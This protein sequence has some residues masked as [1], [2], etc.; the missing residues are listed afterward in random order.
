M[1]IG[2]IAPVFGVILIGEL[3]DKTF[4][5]NLIM[6]SRHRSAPVWV[7]SAIAF[8]VHVVIAV[9]AGNLIAMLPH[10]PVQIVVAAF[11]GAGAAVLL[12]TKEKDQISEGEHE[13][14]LMEVGNRASDARKIAL[15]SFGIIFLGEWGDLT[16]ILI[17]NFSAKYHDPL[18]VGI[19]SLAGLLVALSIAVASGRVLL[20]V[21][22]M[23]MIRRASGL[24]LAGFAIWTIVDAIKS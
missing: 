6:A 4:I 1:H 15:T 17:A 2:V 3:P 7:G 13:A 5:A 22:P 8:A 23:S 18:S 16:Q 9:G 21:L 20:R 11:F 10:L 14:E 12:I 24:I 19:G